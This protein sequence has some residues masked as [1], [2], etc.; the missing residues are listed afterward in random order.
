MINQIITNF[1]DNL[2]YLILQ[3]IAMKYAILTGDIV[4]SRMVDS[5]LWGEQLRLVLSVHSDNYDIYR[6]DSFQAIMPL[7]KAIVC[8]IVLMARLQTIDGIRV[9]L[10]LGIGEINPAANTVRESTGEAYIRSGEAFDDLRRNLFKMSSPW[11]EVD[12]NVNIIMGLCTEIMGR[13]T[14]NMAE[15]FAA[16]IEN[17]DKNQVQL[18]KLLNRKHQ[19][20]LSTELTKAGFAKIQEST[21]YC[22]QLIMKQ[23]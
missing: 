13:W 18:A 12:K 22:T 10:G 16:A 19:S 6:G 11:P 20:Q 8:A 4:N 2:L 9:R 15:S 17:P 21:H 1:D 5:Q 14:V 3:L 7:D 23:C